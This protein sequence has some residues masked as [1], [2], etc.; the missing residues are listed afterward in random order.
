MQETRKLSP[1]LLNVC[2][3][4]LWRGI[5]FVMLTILKNIYPALVDSDINFV[6]WHMVMFLIFNIVITQTG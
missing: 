3:P 6:L 1:K 4:P 2:C 5:T